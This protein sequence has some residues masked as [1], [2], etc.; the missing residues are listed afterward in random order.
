MFDQVKTPAMCVCMLPGSKQ[1]QL[2]LKCHCNVCDGAVVQVK[3]DALVHTRDSNPEPEATQTRADVADTTTCTPFLCLFC[4]VLLMHG[5]RT[6]FLSRHA[7]FIA[8]N[9]EH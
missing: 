9:D 1:R 7:E 4:S 3:G 2:G 5:S 6:P 8:A